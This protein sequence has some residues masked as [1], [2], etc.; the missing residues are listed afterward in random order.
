[1]KLTDTIRRAARSLGNAKGRTILTALAIAVGAFTLTA[2]L[3]AS[4]GASDYTNNLISTNFDPAE[5]IVA[6]DDSLFGGGAPGFGGPQEY[7]PGAL[8]TGGVTIK[9][10]SID[11]I[12]AIESVN[13]IE[14]LRREYQLRP[15]FVSSGESKR[16]TAE[17]NVYSKNQV[18]SLAAGDL[19]DGVSGNQ[20]VLSDAYIELL[21]FRSAQD[22]IGKTIS[23]TFQR[24]A[25]PNDEQLR[26]AFL[27]GGIE[28]VQNLAN[29]EQRAYDLTVVAVSEKA[30]TALAADTALKVDDELADEMSRF[31]TEGT[32]QFEK[33][34]FAYAKV[35][36]GEDASAREAVA[37]EL[38]EK[39][40]TVQT[41]EDTQ[42]TLLQFISILTGIVL[43]FGSLVLIASVFGI[44]NTQYISVLER[45]R[46]IGLNK[47]LG[48]SR[49]SVMRLFLIEAAWIG[50]IGG[51]LGAGLAVIIGTL[52]NPWLSQTIGFP[53][54]QYLLVF[55]PL[56]IIAVVTLLTVIAMIAGLLP[57][58][59]AA[60]LDPIEALRTE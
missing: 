54:G 43:G 11:D 48:M 23:V 33:Y 58:L 59:K 16:Y 8:T 13:G 27:S 53:E 9:Q 5:L 34:I 35:T 28:A 6:K 42:A 17:I 49:S 21:G 7:D 51:A 19:S 45:T 56:S 4:K 36:N 55:E 1:M 39:G 20:V 50:F 47:A 14:S 18:S 44:I 30:A 52:T 15:E 46:E 2:T 60:K 37:S 41:V 31:T 25:R 57:A 26:D 12:K 3:A 38:R 29:T 10:L 32:N 24:T 22:A 40:Y